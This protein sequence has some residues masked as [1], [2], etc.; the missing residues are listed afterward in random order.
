METVETHDITDA[1]EEEIDE[2]LGYDP[3]PTGLDECSIALTRQWAA[4]KQSEA[5]VDYS[6]DKDVLNLLLNGV[7]DTS[8]H[9][10]L[11]A[12]LDKYR[13]L[14]DRWGE[15][16]GNGKCPRCNGTGTVNGYEHVQGGKCFR[17]GGNGEDPHHTY[18]APP[19]PTNP[20]EKL[21]A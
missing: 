16:Q 6:T 21:D 8:H 11:Q 20:A 15:L 17:C 19:T 4:C 1:S 2:L 3:L 7:E 13:A 9:D 12:H 10:R 14:L 5:E 18:Q